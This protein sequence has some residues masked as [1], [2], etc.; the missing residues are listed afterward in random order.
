MSGATSG[1]EPSVEGTTGT[2]P[3][4]PPMFDS[5][6]FVKSEMDYRA[7]V[8]RRGIAVRPRRPRTP[9]RQRL[10]RLRRAPRP[11]ETLS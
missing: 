10:G 7:E 8:A 9:L 5:S 4:E 3:E 2:S 6:L 1:G 11:T